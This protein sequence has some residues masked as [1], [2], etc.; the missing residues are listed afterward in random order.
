MEFEIDYNNLNDG[1]IPE[2][3]AVGAYISTM[4]FHPRYKFKFSLELIVFSLSINFFKKEQHGRNN[5]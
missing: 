3:I 4:K 1:Y 2:W 5:N